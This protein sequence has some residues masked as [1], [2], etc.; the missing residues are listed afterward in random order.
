MQSLHQGHDILS[1]LCP[2][3]KNKSRFFGALTEKILQKG[4]FVSI[5]S[6]FLIVLAA[7]FALRFASVAIEQKITNNTVKASV[8]EKVGWLPGQYIAD[9]MDFTAYMGQ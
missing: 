9:E 2:P 5:A 4:M 6:A 1:V 7:A 8:E 3:Q